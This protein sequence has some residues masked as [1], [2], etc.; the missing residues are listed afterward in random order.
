MAEQE[1]QGR[2]SS[3]FEGY[4][5]LIPK[6]DDTELTKAYYKVAKTEK[7][8]WTR[9]VKEAEDE[10]R[11]LKRYLSFLFVKVLH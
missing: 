2:R 3:L 11:T 8:L 9:A 1:S 6:E 5:E 4:Q 10:Y 7:E